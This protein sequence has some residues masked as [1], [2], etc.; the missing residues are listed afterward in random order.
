MRSKCHV[1]LRHVECVST[2]LQAKILAFILCRNHSAKN[3]AVSALCHRLT[4]ERQRI[5]KICGTG[6]R[7]STKYSFATANNEE[8]LSFTLVYDSLGSKIEP[9][10]DNK[11]LKP[12]KQWSHK[13]KIGCRSTSWQHFGDITCWRTCIYDRIR[14][15]LQRNVCGPIY[16]ASFCLKMDDFI[17]KTHQQVFG[18]R[19]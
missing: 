10:I 14:C 16:A 18:I 8:C 6:G 17:D 19:G 1:R 5:T 13:I 4:T 12:H 15:F 2:Q 9:Q 7:L 3:L 11:P